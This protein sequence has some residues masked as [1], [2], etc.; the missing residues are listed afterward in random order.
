MKLHL[1]LTLANCLPDRPTSN[2]SLQMTK[3][4]AE[5]VS[6]LSKAVEVATPSEIGEQ[7]TYSSI[8]MTTTNITPSRAHLPRKFQPEDTL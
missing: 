5:K 1:N 2:F 4:G 8:L 7:H 6:T 3:Y